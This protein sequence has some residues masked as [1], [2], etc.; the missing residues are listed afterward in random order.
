MNVA[1]LKEM[2]EYMD[3]DAEVLFMSQPSWPFEYSIAGVV[4]RDQFESDSEHPGN[5]VFLIEGTQLRY[6][7]KDAFD[8]Y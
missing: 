6:G 2:L 1:E 4:T 7:S 8:A 3:D 5:D